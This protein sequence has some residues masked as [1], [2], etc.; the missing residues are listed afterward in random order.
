MVVLA[1]NTQRDPISEEVGLASLV[2]RMEASRATTLLVG[3]RVAAT[4]TARGWI[5]ERWVVEQPKGGVCDRHG[6]GYGHL[7]RLA[8]RAVGKP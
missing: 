5:V 8:A 2:A 6:A 3:G 4:R 1:S 7:I